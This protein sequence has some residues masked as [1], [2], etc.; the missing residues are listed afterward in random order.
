MIPTRHCVQLS[1]LTPASSCTS[2]LLG[3]TLSQEKM[4]APES[5]Y[6]SKADLPPRQGVSTARQSCPTLLFT[7]RALLCLLSAIIS[8]NTSPHKPPAALEAMTCCRKRKNLHQHGTK[9]K[10]S[11]R[12]AINCVGV[13]QELW[14]FLPLLLRRGKNSSAS[15]LPGSS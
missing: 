4:P 2:P 7:A 10:E 15:S 8:Q 13:S 14:D 12:T 11:R 1:A 6:H 9:L 5:S 3:E